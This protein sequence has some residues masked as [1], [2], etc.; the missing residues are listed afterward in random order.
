[1]LFCTDMYSILKQCGA[2]IAA[3]WISAAFS[4]LAGYGSVPC[5]QLPTN[6]GKAIPFAVT[7]GPPFIFAVFFPSLF[8]KVS[9]QLFVSNSSEHLIVQEQPEGII[10]LL[11][12]SAEMQALDAAG[13]YGGQSLHR[14]WLHA[15]MAPV[16]FDEHLQAAAPGAFCLSQALQS[17]QCLSLLGCLHGQR[18]ARFLASRCPCVVWIAYSWHGLVRTVQRVLSVQHQGGSCPTGLATNQPDYCLLSLP[19]ADTMQS[20]CAPPGHCDQ[21]QVIPGGRISLVLTGGIAA[22]II[23]NQIWSAFAPS[24]WNIWGWVAHMSRTS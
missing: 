8:F 1:M 5:L 21:L 18:T 12:I 3:T 17:S 19:V 9:S 4:L 10:R 13:T 7:W 22:A 14:D 23:C 11:D 6:N 2:V 16:L 24:S 15:H 20:L